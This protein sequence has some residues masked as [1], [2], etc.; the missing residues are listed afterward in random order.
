MAGAVDDSNTNIVVVIIIIIIIIII[1]AKN[2]VVVVVSG[3]AT[4]TADLGEAFFDFV[5]ALVNVCAFFALQHALVCDV[6]RNLKIGQH[7]VHHSA[8]LLLNS[9][10]QSSSSY[11]ATAIGSSS[12]SSSSSSYS[13][14]KWLFS[15]KHH[16]T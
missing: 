16:K 12:S 8:D 6:H 13:F 10:C 1:L 4:W 9:E 3:V 2:I 14:N 5:V 11:D 15:R 7:L